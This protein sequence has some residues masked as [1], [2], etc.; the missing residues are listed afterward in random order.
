V[1]LTVWTGL[2]Q[3]QQNSSN[4]QLQ[5]L[6]DQ[7]SAIQFNLNVLQPTVTSMVSQVA[8]LT[9]EAATL[10]T[11]VATLT[12]DWGNLQPIVSG[13][14]TQVATLTT[15]VSTL[16]AGQLSA[17]VCQWNTGPL[18][19]G[20]SYH[21]WAATD[22]SGGLPYI[23]A[24]GTGYMISYTGNGYAFSCSIGNAMSAG[25]YLPA[26]AQADQNESLYCLYI[27]RTVNQ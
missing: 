5:N 23:N 16:T 12:Q 7:I 13:L 20:W 17:T 6:Q 11:E 18:P 26:N 22:C 3:F 9:T 24:M 21:T 4:N 14:S 8:T 19:F 15:Q 25:A 1:G 10:T 27:W 2:L